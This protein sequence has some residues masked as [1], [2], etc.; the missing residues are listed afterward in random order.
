MHH[1]HAQSTERPSTVHDSSAAADELPP[2]VSGIIFTPKIAPSAVSGPRQGGGGSGNR[3]AAD[4]G[5]GEAES[6]ARIV[7]LVTG[8]A[9]GEGSRDEFGA[10]KELHSVLQAWP[11]PKGTP[12]GPGA[13]ARQEVRMCVCARARL[14]RRRCNTHILAQQLQ[15][16]DVRVIMPRPPDSSP[17]SCLPKQVLKSNARTEQVVD[18]CVR[19]LKTGALEADVAR[20]AVD[21]LALLATEV[22]ARQVLMS[23]YLLLNGHVH[24]RV[25][26][27]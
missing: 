1:A 12:S 11:S 6:A 27:Q 23:E 24:A 14:S 22:A 4:G 5:R 18:V 21:V 17:Q 26:A 7:A 19:G 16:P 2:P 15:N 13:V 9:E 25:M 8:I 10:L 20:A 3:G